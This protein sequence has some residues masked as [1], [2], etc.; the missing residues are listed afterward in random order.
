MRAVVQRVKYGAVIINHEKV[1]EIGAGAV[2]LLGVHNS[3]TAQDAAYLA[4]KCANLRIFP[5][6]NG[7]MNRSLLEIAGEALVIS[8]FT[9]YGDTRKGRRPSFVEAARPEVSEP[10]YEKFV[11]ELRATGIRTATGRFGA[12][13]FVKIHNDGPVTLIVE[14][15]STGS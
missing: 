3:D 13:M 1:G 4:Q 6:E 11:E 10:L 8:Q 9:L 7:N 2:I 5:D 15:K 14:S 12:M